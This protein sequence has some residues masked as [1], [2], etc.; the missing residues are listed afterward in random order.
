[1]SSN[2]FV[3]NLPYAL[4]DEELAALFTPYDDVTSAKIIMDRETGR[5]RGFGFV[6]LASSD[7]GEKAINEL[8][9]TQVQGRSIVVRAAEPRQ[10]RG[11]GQR[12]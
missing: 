6:E 2:L 11:G 9:G 7:A 1:M 3:A 5:S 10:K 4:V 12:G 8:H